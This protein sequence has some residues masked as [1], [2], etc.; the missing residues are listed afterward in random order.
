MVRKNCPMALF[1]VDFFL[2]GVEGDVA[3]LE[4]IDQV[5]GVDRAPAEAIELADDHGVDGALGDLVEELLKA[6]SVGAFTGIALVADDLDQ[7]ELV[8]L[9]VGCDLMGLGVEAD[10]ATSLLLGG[11]SDVSECAHS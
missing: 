9:G 10:P 1:G 5:Q 8:E 6:R 4:G 11:N 7:V 3:G 2:D